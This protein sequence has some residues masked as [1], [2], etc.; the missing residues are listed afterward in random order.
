MKTTITNVLTIIFCLSIG[1]LADASFVLTAIKTQSP[2]VIDGIIDEEAW[3]SASVAAN[4]MQ[5]EPYLGSP[6]TTRTDVKVLYDAQKLYAAFKLWDSQP[7]A[8]QLT[9]R[10]ADLFDDDSVI[11]ILDTHHDRRSAYYFMTNALSTQADGRIV[12]DGRTVDDTWDAPW[13]CAAQI[14]DSGWTVEMAI[15][16]TSNPDFATIRFELALPEKRQFFLEGNE[17]FKQRIR[18]FYSRRIPDIITG[19]FLVKRWE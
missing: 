6:S 15:P 8:A 2:L 18:T 5:Y 13:E 1:L 14:S 17:L 12:D 11:L 3:E 19:C 16:F 4:F 9:R 10:D 7:P